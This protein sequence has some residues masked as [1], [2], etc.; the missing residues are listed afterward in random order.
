MNTLF[1]FG[2]GFTLQMKIQPNIPDRPP[3][4]TRT[5]NPYDTT[6]VRNFVSA[7]F[8]GSV[9]LE[10]H[11]VSGYFVSTPQGEFSNSCILFSSVLEFETI[12]MMISLSNIC[13][14]FLT[15][16][17]TQSLLNFTFSI[18]FIGFCNLSYTR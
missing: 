13:M 17:D 11:Q 16:K 8:P 3:L 15:T 9:L 10:E 4:V 2:S 1:R 14:S 12:V 6:A 18:N 7:N 5:V